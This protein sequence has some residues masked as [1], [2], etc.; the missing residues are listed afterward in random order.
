MWVC[1]GA[2][3]LG[4]QEG[5]QAEQRPF[6]TLPGDA[7]W[8]MSFPAGL[9]GLNHNFIRSYELNSMDDQRTVLQSIPWP[10]FINRYRHS[11]PPFEEPMPAS[12][13][14]LMLSAHSFLLIRKEFASE[15]GRAVHP[16]ALKT[17]T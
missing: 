17:H 6:D 3:P 9:A 15:H 16:Q 14:D 7:P 10:G 1:K 4:G 8:H 5:I 2:K 12:Y 13:A 11:W